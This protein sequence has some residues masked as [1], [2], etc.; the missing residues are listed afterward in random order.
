KQVH[1]CKFRQCLVPDKH[2]CYHCKR[3]VPFETSSED[4]VD[5]L[6]QWKMKRSYEYLNG[7]V[8]LLTVNLR[9]NND[10]KLLMN[11]RDTTNVTFYVA[12][13]QMK[14][15]GKSH[16]ISAVLAKGFAYHTQRSPYLES[17]WDQQHLLLFR[18][19]HAINREQEIAAPMVISYLMGWGDTFHSHHY[20]PMYWSSFVGALLKHYPEL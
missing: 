17:L 8:P 2:G 13:Y 14:K 3:R 4:M 5:E 15:Q 12:V 16:N 6:G 1:K 19:I 7:W 9:C 11:S 20:V 18:L 10:G